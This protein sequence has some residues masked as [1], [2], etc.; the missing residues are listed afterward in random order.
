MIYTKKEIKQKAKWTY[1]DF[2]FLPAELRCEIIDQSLF[3]AP[4]PSFEHQSSSGNL[5]SLLHTYVKKKK[6]GAVVAA[7]MDVVFDN[8]N[9]VQPDIIFVSQANG[10]IIKDVVHGVPDCLIEVVSPGYVRFDRVKKYALYEKFGVKEYW[11]VDPG[12]KLIEVFVLENKKYKL[13]SCAEV[14]GKV[15]SKIVS[16]FTVDIKKVFSRSI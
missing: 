15:F 16:G 13:H 8:N 1:A 9:V 11:I 12:N 14:K 5:F 2:S 4:S 6:L 3:M 7:P 10:K